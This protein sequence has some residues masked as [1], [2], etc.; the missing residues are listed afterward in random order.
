MISFVVFYLFMYFI[1]NNW[2]IRVSVSARN[3]TSRCSI[4]RTGRSRNDCSAGR[5]VGGGLILMLNCRLLKNLLVRLT[6]LLLVVVFA[7]AFNQRHNPEELNYEMVSLRDI[8]AWHTVAPLAHQYFCNWKMLLL[9]LF[10]PL[11]SYIF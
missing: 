7:E 3:F 4:S 1:L 8:L 10:D 2:F 9:V 6:R 11:S 5:A